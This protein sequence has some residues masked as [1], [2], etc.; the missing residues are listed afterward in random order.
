MNFEILGVLKKMIRMAHLSLLI[1]EE[2]LQ[3]EKVY[4]SGEK[5]G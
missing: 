1:L 5:V 2:Y 4:K 3:L